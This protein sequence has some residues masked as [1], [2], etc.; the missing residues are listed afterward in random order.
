MENEYIR[1]LV[2]IGCMV[3]SLVTL[4]ECRVLLI[5]KIKHHK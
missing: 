4:F 3:N 5:R 1:L 2:P